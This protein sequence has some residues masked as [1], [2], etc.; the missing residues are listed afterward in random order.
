MTLQKYDHIAY[1]DADGS[2]WMQKLPARIRRELLTE[3][4]IDALGSRL[5]ASHTVITAARA[6]QDGASEDS[7]PAEL[8]A[9][10][11]HHGDALIAHIVDVLSDGVEAVA[12]ARRMFDAE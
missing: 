2:S 9:T 11:R 7:S 12:A 6:A 10:W 8:V 3:R 1:T 4:A 5:T